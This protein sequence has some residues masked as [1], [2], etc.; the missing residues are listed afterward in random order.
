MKNRIGFMGLFVLVAG[1]M[2][3]LMAIL[4]FEIPVSTVGIYALFALCIGSHFFMHARHGAHA[5]H[6]HHRH[7]HDGLTTTPAMK[8]EHT[9]Q[10]NSCH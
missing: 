6:N 2:V 10:S 7:N 4:L 3:A 1:L 8:E 9:S 5:G